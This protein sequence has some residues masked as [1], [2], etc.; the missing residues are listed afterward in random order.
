MRQGE[1]SLPED[2]SVRG[3]FQNLVRGLLL[4]AADGARGFRPV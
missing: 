2:A 3:V 4:R 1:V